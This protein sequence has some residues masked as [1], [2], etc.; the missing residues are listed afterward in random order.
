MNSLKP[1]PFCGSKAKA[2]RFDGFWNVA[3]NK[4]TCAFIHD[5]FG[6]EAEAIAAWNRRAEPATHTGD[7]EPQRCFPGSESEAWEMVESLARSWG[8]QGSGPINALAVAIMGLREA[9]NGR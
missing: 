6:T 7:Q 8:N 2:Y 9:N 1:C 5:Y 3:C 4:P